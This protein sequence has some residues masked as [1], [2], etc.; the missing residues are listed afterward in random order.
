M[1]LR[2]YA[3]GLGMAVALAIPAYA[4]EKEAM[5]LRNAPPIAAYEEQVNET[6]AARGVKLAQQES[7]IGRI[8]RTMR[9]S[10]LIE[11]VEKRYDADKGTLA[12]VVMNE[13]YGNPVMPNS[14]GDGGL[15]LV[16]FQPPTARAYG[17]KIHGKTTGAYKDHKNGKSIEQMLKNCQYSV[18]CAA[19]YDDRAHLLRNL[20]A[21]MRLIREGRERHGSWDAGIRY[22]NWP[23]GKNYVNRIKDFR[24]KYNSSTWRDKAE[25]D[26]EQRN[27]MDFDDY[28]DLSQDRMV[29]WGLDEYKQ[30][31]KV[32]ANAKAQAILAANKGKT[33]PVAAK[34]DKAIAKVLPEDRTG[35][36]I[37]SWIISKING[38]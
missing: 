1:N 25:R 20:D 3:L 11:A 13:S 28:L 14:R 6:N 5:A 10:P 21:T 22:I 12:A 27:K 36:G 38:Q 37:K 17:L 15:G 24:A 8:Q 32:P 29:N 34:K 19:Q 33:A 2:N 18:P 31:G 35:D 4:G 23:A 9:W 7:Y 26:F 16:H 30:L